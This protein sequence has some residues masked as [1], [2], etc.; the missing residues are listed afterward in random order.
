MIPS[1]QHQGFGGSPGTPPTPPSS[2]GDSPSGQPRR[3]NKSSF[4]SLVSMPKSFM[5][6]NEFLNDILLSERGEHKKLKAIVGFFVGIIFGGVLFLGLY[7]GLEYGLEAAVV[8]TALSTTLMA[9]SL[10]FTGMYLLLV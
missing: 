8:I 7:Y 1:P 9:V 4:S 2:G 3:R 10:A 6:S 5:A